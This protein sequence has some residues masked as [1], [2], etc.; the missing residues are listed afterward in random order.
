MSA[1]AKQIRPYVQAE[2]TAAAEAERQGYHHLAFR[3]MERAHVL[4]QGAVI[5]HVRVHGH[6]LGYALRH[7]LVREILGQ[8]PRLL[9]AAPLSLVGLIPTGNTGGSNVSGLR[10][11]PV[12][13]DL[14]QII[15]GA[16]ARAG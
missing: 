6:M 5:E 12:P 13:A 2:L 10:P 8:I 15:D 9:L 7:G 3:R 4:S 1:F 11:M 16:R 14:Q